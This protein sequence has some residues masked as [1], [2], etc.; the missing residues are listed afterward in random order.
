MILQGRYNFFCKVFFLYILT[1]LYF[2]STGIHVY[3]LDS[4]IYTEHP[5]FAGRARMEAN[6]IDYE[7]DGDYA[8][9]GKKKQFSF[10]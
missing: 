1:I 4:G 5:D 7:D 6:Y 2:Y 3:I 8:G 10:F 9:H